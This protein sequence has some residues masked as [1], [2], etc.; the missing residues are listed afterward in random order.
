VKKTFTNHG[1]ES[2][3]TKDREYLLILRMNSVRKIIENSSNPLTIELPK[4]Y[5]NKKL[6]V[7][8]LQLEDADEKQ[9]TLSEFFGKMQWKGDALAEQ[10]KLRDEWD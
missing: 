3:T 2:V 7:I 1:A 8:I 9:N 10:K 6:E 5:E 4:E